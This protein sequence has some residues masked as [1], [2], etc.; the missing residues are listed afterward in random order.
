ML[1]T[2]LVNID[3][4][5][6]RIKCWPRAAKRWNEDDDNDDEDEDEDDDDGIL[7]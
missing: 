4:M 1:D 3:K 2:R 6:L 7:D 5:F